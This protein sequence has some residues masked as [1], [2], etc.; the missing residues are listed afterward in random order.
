MP[1]VRRKSRDVGEQTVFFT[2]ISQNYV[3]QARCLFESLRI[4]YPDARHV[5]CLVEESADPEIF[6]DE[7][8]EVVLAKEVVGHGF[9][10]MAYK[11]SL[12]ELNTAVKP[13]AMKWLIDNG[14]KYV[15]YVD[16]DCYLYSPMEEVFNLFTKGSSIIITPH[17]MEPIE[18]ASAPSEVDF[19][20]AGTFNLGF[21]SVRDT[22]ET[23][24]FLAWWGD[25][26]R[27]LCVF[28]PISGLFVDQKW[29]ELAPSFFQQVAI[30]RH[31]GYNVAYWN[32]FQRGIERL[33]GGWHVQGEPL[34]FFHFSSLPTEDVSK[35][36]RHQDR[37]DGDAIGPFITEFH[38][39]LARLASNAL[40][41]AQ[42]K[43]YSYNL[44]WQGKPIESQALRAALRRAKGTTATSVSDL[45][46]EQSIATLL[47][48]ESALPIDEMFPISRL[49][50]DAWLNSPLVARQY[51]LFTAEGRA[52]FLYW[53]I[54][55]GYQPLQI[56]RALLPWEELTRPVAKALGGR[57][58]VPPIVWLVWLADSKLRRTA[59]LDSEA[60]YAKLLIELQR[61]ISA[62]RRPASIL[63]PEYWLAVVLGDGDDRIN[64]AQY[65]IWSTRPDLQVTFDLE[66]EDGRR[67]FVGW[68]HGPSP[69]VETPWMAELL[70][71]AATARV[72]A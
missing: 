11:Y 10:E 6:S 59:S 21:I 19:L 63:P 38:T 62:G 18:D 25:R 58:A 46:S 54:T 22:P 17:V 5:L 68:C 48:P 49:I 7:G 26:L 61:Q 27:N 56:D 23:R 52:R 8:F 15:T 60:N 42:E 20:R 35:I 31:P 30:L 55:E 65:V 36:A 57:L 34:R 51:P 45:R 32:I 33:P 67:D 16:P 44:T 70:R 9:Y 37:L 64:V 14:A 4:H 2:I 29:I 1:K 69:G 24:R 3:P 39:Y 50:Y 71:Q 12:V 43:R 72:E 66:S 28:D 40:K 13:F 53:V 47:Q 41:P